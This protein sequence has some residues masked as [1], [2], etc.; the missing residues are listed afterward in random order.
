MKLGIIIPTYR[1]LDGST[2]NHLKNALESVKNQSY[3]DYKVFLIGDNYSDHNELMDLSG[4]IDPNK[5]YVENLIVAVERVKYNGI[6]LWRN[7]GTNASNVGIKKALEDGF[8]YICHLD[9]D[10]FYLENHLKTIS[11]CIEK[12]KTKFITTKCGAYPDIQPSE[13]YTDY[14]PI[15]SK[16]NKVSTCI[17][18]RYFNMFFRNMIEETGE[19]YASDA[20]MW[21][22]INDYLKA[23]N[24]W[25]VFINETTCCKIGGQVPIWNPNI[26]K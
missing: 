17:N 1:K 5:I 9:H 11:S 15:S 24:E 6:D 26:I 16:L 18:Y 12:T 19:S 25:G 21:N 8:D 13:F 20:D 4:T 22:R 7:G 3:Q 10:D 2:Y 14:R 23:K